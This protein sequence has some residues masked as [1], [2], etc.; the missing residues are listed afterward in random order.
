MK[1]ILDIFSKGCQ[2]K[3]CGPKWAGTNK[4][5]RKM[6]T[7]RSTRMKPRQ[8]RPEAVRVGF[9]AEPERMAPVHQIPAVAADGRNPMEVPG[10]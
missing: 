5:R 1:K 2:G 8:K 4:R 6:S 10:M 9:C 7:L 3:A